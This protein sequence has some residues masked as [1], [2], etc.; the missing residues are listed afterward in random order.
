[1]ITSFASKGV[2]R[3]MTFG[4]ASSLQEMLMEDKRMMDAL[5]YMENPTALNA[6]MEAELKKNLFF[7]PSTNT[8]HVEPK[9]DKEAD[10]GPDKDRWRKAKEK[11]IGALD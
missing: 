7:D 4:A 5:K 10:N 1:M 3:A 8:Y 2:E 9:T 6:L 11:E